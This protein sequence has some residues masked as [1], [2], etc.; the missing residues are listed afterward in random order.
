MSQLRARLLQHSPQVPGEVLLVSPEAVTNRLRPVLHFAYETSISINFWW[1]RSAHDAASNGLADQALTARLARSAQEISRPDLHNLIRGRRARI[2]STLLNQITLPVIGSFYVHD[3]LFMARLHPLR[4][5]ERL[6]DTEID[7]LFDAMHDGLEPAIEKGSAD[8]EVDV[9]REKG[10]FG[11]DD[12]LSVYREGEPCPA[13]GTA[14]QKTKT[15]S[16]SSLICSQCQP[17]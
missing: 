6:T 3:I 1:M 15:G 7:G 10:K 5:A 8:P 16:A 2:R 4:T 9:S 11:A 14:I 13:C 17:L 12:M